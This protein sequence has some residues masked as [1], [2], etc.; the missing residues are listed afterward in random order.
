MSWVTHDIEEGTAKAKALLNGAVYR[1]RLLAPLTSRVIDVN[2][3]VMVVGGGIAGIQ[4]SLELANTGKK[5]IWWKRIPPSAA[6]WRS[7]TRPFP[8]SDCSACILTPK[9][10]AVLQHKNITLMTYCEVSEV[11]GFIG[12]F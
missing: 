12:N 2:D 1:A 9:M 4:A 8:P 7:L 10:D 11:K 6:T 3:D 5:S